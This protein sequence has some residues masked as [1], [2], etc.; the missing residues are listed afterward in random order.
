MPKEG[1]MTEGMYFTSCTILH[2]LVHDTLPSK[3]MCGGCVVCGV[4]EIEG[5]PRIYIMY[6]ILCG[7]CVV[8]GV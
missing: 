8:C 6:I 7:G 3:K 1:S 5:A 4:C 2:A